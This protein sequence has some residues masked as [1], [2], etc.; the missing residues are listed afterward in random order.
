MMSL[1]LWEGLMG[2]EKR[3]SIE[4]YRFEH[5]KGILKIHYS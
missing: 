3:D 1:R 4:T 2:R 5:W